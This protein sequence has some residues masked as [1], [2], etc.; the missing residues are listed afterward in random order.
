[1][2]DG[3]LHSHSLTRTPS[4]Y[5]ILSNGAAFAAAGEEATELFDQMT[6]AMKNV[7][8]GEKK[9]NELFAALGGLLHLGN[10]EFEPE[11]T[12]AK[13]TLSQATARIRNHSVLVQ[14]ARLLCVT[15]EDLEIALLQSICGSGGE[16]CSRCLDVAQA[17]QKRN[18]IVASIYASLRLWILN[19][20]N[21]RFLFAPECEE[22]TVIRIIDTAFANDSMQDICSFGGFCQ[23]LA[24][25]KT[26]DTWNKHLLNDQ[27]EAYEKV[28]IDCKLEPRIQHA[29]ESEKAYLQ[30]LNGRVGANSFVSFNNSKGKEMKVALVDLL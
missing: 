25:E 8:L 10:I 1:M 11:P 24:Y 5:K 22:L 28:R 4:H 14:A 15:E 21:G 26:L 18:F 20:L 12:K 3:L 9:Q 6:I 17:E 13:H 19:W 29:V 7:G 27:L 30:A 23:N 2:P 16:T